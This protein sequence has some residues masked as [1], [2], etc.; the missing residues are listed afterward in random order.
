MGIAC[1]LI[2]LA[3]GPGEYRSWQYRGTSRFEENE[4]VPQWSYESEAI[5]AEV[6]IRSRQGS[7]RKIMIIFIRD[8]LRLR[9]PCVTPPCTLPPCVC[10]FVAGLEPLS[11]MWP[12]EGDPAED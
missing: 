5:W 8:A 10:M 1:S 3:K 7:Q 4:E 6:K 12:P 2:L 9:I 11:A